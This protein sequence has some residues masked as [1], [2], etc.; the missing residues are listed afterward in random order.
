[1][2]ISVAMPLRLDLDTLILLKCDIAQQSTL[3]LQT[4]VEFPGAMVRERMFRRVFWRE[5][6]SQVLADNRGHDPTVPMRP[7]MTEALLAG[8]PLATVLA[9]PDHCRRIAAGL[10]PIDLTVPTVGRAAAVLA[11]PDT[12]RPAPLVVLI[13][14]WWGLTDQ[15]KGMAAHMASLGYLTLAVDLMNGQVATTQDEA[16]AL[17]GKVRG[18]VARDILVGWIEWGRT[19]EGGDGRV[20]V[21]GWCFGG[22]LALMASLATPVEATVIYSGLT[23][24]RADDLT[25]L[26]GPV[27]GHFGLHDRFVPTSMITR[28]ATEMHTANRDFRH[29]LYDAGHG[30]ANPT[31]DRHHHAETKRA[32]RRTLAFLAETLPQRPSNGNKTDIRHED[33]TK[34]RIVPDAGL[35]YDP[36]GNDG[37]GFASP[38]D[39]STPQTVKPGP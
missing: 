9:N 35:G 33:A 2:D 24:G 14:E 12:R 13:H 31:S 4:A 37:A 6:W 7:P 30:F 15:I 32:W 36:A 39:C 1:M 38:C 3:I 20:G 19:C 18:A 28:F 29:H 25:A 16:V 11:R 26:K 27:L 8:V 17:S 22:G 10:T 23:M 21:L 34:K 5:P